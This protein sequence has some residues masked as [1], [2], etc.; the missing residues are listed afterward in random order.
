V[1]R[2]HPYPV[3]CGR[4][5]VVNQ[6]ASDDEDAPMKPTGLP[7]IRRDIDD[8]MRPVRPSDHAVGPGLK[9]RAGDRNHVDVIRPT[10]RSADRRYRP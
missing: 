3:T 9:Q 6:K 4:Y 7:V 8:D 2:S 10:S 1:H 5:G